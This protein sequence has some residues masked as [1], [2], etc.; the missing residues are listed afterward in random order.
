MSNFH[1]TQVYIEKEQMRLLKIEAGKERLSAS[2]LI[3][4]AIDMFLKTKG[5]DINWNNDPLTKAIGNIHLG[6]SNASVK[7]DRYLYGHKK[8]S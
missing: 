7:H 5:R 1:R 8:R 4:R 6:V 2:E 3:R